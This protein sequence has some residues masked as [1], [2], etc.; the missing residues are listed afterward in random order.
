M[1]FS[2]ELFNRVKFDPRY[3]PDRSMTWFRH[4][5]ARMHSM[6]IRADALLTGKDKKL[7]SLMSPGNMYLYK[8]D[9]KTKEDLPHWDRYPLII[10]FRVKGRHF[11]GL[12]VHYLH[13]AT[14]A[15]LLERLMQFKN[16]NDKLMFTW[17]M[18]KNGK[19]F[20]GVNRAVKQYLFNH[21]RSRFL[22]IEKDD[23][24]IAIFLPVEGFVGATKSEVWRG[25]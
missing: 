13:P 10:P 23:W 18:V 17:N 19:R 1:H 2:Q 12:N 22:E 5:V 4:Q 6:D 16:P 11:W 9:P 8:Y 20:P 3:K 15:I 14:R 7:R 21:V 25:K 24:P